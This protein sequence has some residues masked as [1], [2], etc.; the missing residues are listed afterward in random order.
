[1]NLHNL[2]EFFLNLCIFSSKKGHKK[3]KRNHPN[4][5]D[6]AEPSSKPISSLIESNTTKTATVST[7]HRKW[8]IPPT[9][10][11]ATASC[12]MTPTN[13]VIEPVY[14][15][16]VDDKTPVANLVNDYRRF[17]G[18]SEAWTPVRRVICDS[19]VHL[20]RRFSFGS[21]G[22]TQAKRLKT[23]D[24]RFITCF[25]TKVYVFSNHF[26]RPAL[27]EVDGI[28]FHHFILLF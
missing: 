24:G 2:F 19:V 27:F 8:I 16:V 9:S 3:K 7:P 21:V 15:P 13:R 22:T 4:E 26:S 18:G 12:T 1:M 28:Y 20:P 17:G 5:A 25:F 11:S 6:D 14:A 10:S 23:A